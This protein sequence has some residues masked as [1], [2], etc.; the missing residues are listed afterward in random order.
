M[1]RDSLQTYLKL[2]EQLDKERTQIQQ[3]LTEIE[4]ALGTG[5]QRATAPSPSPRSSARA[6]RPRSTL[7]LREAVQQ[8]IKDR[9]MT[10]EEILQSIKDLGYRFST[11]N[12]LNSLGV[13]LYGKN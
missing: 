2:R 8:V 5:E 11:N 12:P 13:I 10:K 9:A 4:A 6:G 7:S 3:R 1:E